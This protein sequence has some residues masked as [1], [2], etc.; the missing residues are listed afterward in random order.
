MRQW[1]PTIG[2]ICLLAWAGLRAS[3]PEAEAEEPRFSPKNELLRPE[4]Y[5]EWIFV[6]AS[7]GMSYSEAGSASRE[8]RF[9]NLYLHPKAYQHYKRT[10]QFPERTILVMET[11]SAGSQTS[12]NRQG[13]FEDRFTGLEAAV[14]DSS[15]FPGHWAYFNFTG[16]NQTLSP[17]AAA[18]PKE[19]CWDCHH[20]HG[21]TD[22]VFTQFYPVLRR[23]K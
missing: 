18:F 7:L 4:G 21:E 6:G 12:I 19:A 11:L 9:H 1:V 14:K 22:N 2:L 5:R 8:P 20:Q 17:A 15:R 10:G 23:S 13:H 16:P 3:P